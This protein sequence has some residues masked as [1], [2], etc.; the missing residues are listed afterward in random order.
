MSEIIELH[1]YGD[2]A[3]ATNSDEYQ[4]IDISK[5]N[6][7]NPKI[8]I[9]DHS[10]R[11][12][13]IKMDA[14]S[15]KKPRVK[16]KISKKGTSNIMDFITS[17]IISNSD[18]LEKNIV[19]IE[20]LD[21]EEKSYLQKSSRALSMLPV[22]R[23]FIDLEYGSKRYEINP[24]LSGVNVNTDSQK[25][26]LAEYTEPRYFD[27]IVIDYDICETR[28]KSKYLDLSIKYLKFT[29]HHNFSLEE[30][31]VSKLEELYSEYIQIAESLKDLLLNI[32]V[33]RRTRDSLKQKFLKI[34]PKKKDNT[35][36]DPIIQ[37]YTKSLLDNKDNYFKKLKEKRKL[38]NSISSIWSDIS[39]V[40]DKFKN[41]Q[42]PHVL[43][44]DNISLNDQEISNKWNDL[45]ELEYSDIL[46]KL[47]YD[48]VKKYI[49][50]TSQYTQ[51]EK[52]RSKVRK[53]KIQIN[54]EE[55]KEKA[56]ETVNFILACETNMTLHY[57]ETI[58]RNILKN[59]HKDSKKNYFKVYVDNFF[60]CISDVF[61][62]DNYCKKKLLESLTI[63]IL[64]TNN[65][66]YI[67]LYEN[68]EEVSSC[69]IDLLNRKKNKID[70]MKHT[71]IY[72]KVITPELGSVGSGYTIKDILAVNKIRLKSSNTFEGKLFTTCNVLIK[73]IWNDNLNEN[74]NDCIKE[75]INTKIHIER[76]MH[77]V[78]EGN[79]NSLLRIISDLYDYEVSDNNVINSVKEISK[80]KLEYEEI[81][82]IEECA[83]FIR[84]KLLLLRNSGANT[85]LK[86][87]AIP[88]FSSQVSTEQ[89]NCLQATETT[90]DVEYMKRKI[91]EMD[92]IDTQRYIGIQF[93]NKLN[94]KISKELN[95][96]LSSKTHKDVVKDFKDLSLRSIFTFTPKMVLAEPS[97][98]VL[99]HQMEERL[100]TEQDIYVTVLRAFNLYERGA[101]AD[102]ELLENDADNDIAG[103]RMR[104]LR[105]FV[106]I[107]YKDAS[108]Q[109][110]TAVGSHPTWN[111]TV[112]MN[113]KLKPLCSL[114]VNIYD[115]HK[116]SV[117]EEDTERQTFV[118]RSC[119][120]WL[121]TLSVPIHAVLAN[122]ALRGTFKV[123]TPP[124][125]LGYESSSTETSSII[126]EIK[127]LMRKDSAFLTLEI[128]TSLSEYGGC[129]IY[130]Q[131]FLESDHVIK[132]LNSF[133]TE[134]MNDFPNRNISLTFVDS[135]GRNKCVTE[136]IQS[137]SL[138]GSENFPRDPQRIRTSS[139]SSIVS[140]N[141]QK[142][143]ADVDSRDTEDKEITLEELMNFALRYVALIP[144]YELVDSHVVTLK[145]VELL[146]VVFG[147][148]LDHSLLLASYFVHL[149]IRAWVVIGFSLPRGISSYVLVKYRNN[150][151]IMSGE[152]ECGGGWFSRR[153]DVSLAVFDA[154]SGE[155]H[156]VRDVGCPLK[157]V[158]FAFDCENIWVNQQTSLNCEHV[159]FEFHKSS[160]WR[161]VFNKSVFVVKEPAVS[162]A[163]SSAVDVDS[164]RTHL[165][166]RIKDKVQK[167]RW[168]VK[169]IWNR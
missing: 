113:T 2:I 31:L 76:I 53:P 123:T 152:D 18:I 167:W 13:F 110:P 154:V 45:F 56:Q 23:R 143:F 27:D 62:I 130:Q 91:D 1:S 75:Q 131:P 165:E 16:H 141:S 50:Y 48:Y 142:R 98:A 161:S 42:T 95:E 150:H 124:Q 8:I 61:A 97:G 20:E 128:K 156:D 74:Q 133:V 68:N 146:K 115:E 41:V 158:H 84:Y 6:N 132:H 29:H 127:R 164:L 5:G 35:K 88:L 59:K 12:F 40:R 66:L 14:N 71:L 77:G 65:I 149:G 90:E 129:Q 122:G 11:D 106:R 3:A 87:Q 78:E 52:E 60:V 138:P 117:T 7:V 86:N 159:S 126:P 83:E 160:H 63:Q 108:V 64:P 140:K 44:I 112:R 69:S 25:H 96:R 114:H 39:L 28:R 47:E 120:R 157:T 9:D 15:L 101:L 80:T 107:S 118:Y 135:S 169:T 34:S 93:I 109:S 73:V 125:I 67:I 57:D 54:P 119:N 4:E 33:A 70:L 72:D 51:T 49:E 81:F 121:G 30:L 26:S 85:N 17:E 89:L 155:R 116:V 104:T 139:R 102:D 19:N 145:G 148:P 100:A 94:E 103:F 21:E 55:I 166:E 168:N 22:K 43:K 144:T 153:D 82:S 58:L 111:F 147:S 92:P 79:L 137:I 38:S 24:T 136:F 134:F 105:P 36:Y 163:Y 32:E 37:K 46:T 162:Y 151:V 10:E 99:K